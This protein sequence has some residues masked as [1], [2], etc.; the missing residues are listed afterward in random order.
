MTRDGARRGTTPRPSAGRWC[1]AT[2]TNPSIIF[3]NKH[4]AWLW[5]TQ[6]HESPIGSGRGWRNVRLQIDTTAEEIEGIDIAE[7]KPAFLSYPLLNI[8]AVSP[9]LA[10]P[11]DNPAKVYVESITFKAQMRAF[12]AVQ[13]RTMIASGPT[14]GLT[15]SVNNP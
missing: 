3:A 13:Y 14:D 5:H 1:K 9:Q 12:S 7:Q 8:F 11:L 10:P 15:P 2:H 6:I 4:S